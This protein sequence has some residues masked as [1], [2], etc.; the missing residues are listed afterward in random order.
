MHAYFYLLNLPRPSLWLMSERS[1]A[2]SEGPNDTEVRGHIHAPAGRNALCFRAKIPVDSTSFLRSNLFFS[3]I[4]HGFKPG[5]PVES[6]VYF[7]FDCI[8]RNALCFRAKRATVKTTSF[9]RER[10]LDPWLTDWLTEKCN[11]TYKGRRFDR[12]TWF[13]LVTDSLKKYYRAQKRRRFVRKKWFRPATDD[14]EKCSRTKKR[15]R[16]DRMTMH[17]KWILRGGARGFSRVLG[18]YFKKAKK[19]KKPKSALTKS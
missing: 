10:W 8:F 6:T 4:G 16:F 15:C 5:F 2:G 11:R 1:E 18:L 14:R 12:K 7:S 3:I 17:L 13:E 9:R 19:A